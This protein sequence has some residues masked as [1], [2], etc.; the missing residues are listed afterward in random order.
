MLD[1]CA[2]QQTSHLSA[3]NDPTGRPWPRAWARASTGLSATTCPS[4]LYIS[5][6]R[7]WSLQYSHIPAD[8]PFPLPD[9]LHLPS[10]GPGA[11][12]WP[13]TVQPRRP[14]NAFHTTFS[15]GNSAGKTSEVLGLSTRPRAHLNG[16]YFRW[17][18]FYSFL[19]FLRHDFCSIVSNE[20]FLFKIMLLRHVQ[21]RKP[22]NEALIDSLLVYI[23]VSY[24]RGFTLR[25]ATIR[26]QLNE[27]CHYSNTP[28]EACHYS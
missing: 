15:R 10:M 24:S 22:K 25:H 11:A 28:I 5:A 4:D 27:A 8:K 14:T 3:D 2:V 26:L 7:P 23:E 16:D 20:R 9:D 13:G 1:L 21:P 17:A 19:L 18:G 12:R 6:E